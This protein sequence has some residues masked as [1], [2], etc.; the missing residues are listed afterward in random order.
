MIRPVLV[1]AVIVS[2]LAVVNQ[3][4][5]MPELAEEL[6]KP[7]ADDGSIKVKVTSS[8]DANGVLLHG[9][10]GDRD[11]Q[12]VIKFFVT[13]PPEVAGEPFDVEAAQATYVPDD[14]RGTPMRG[15]WLL[16]GVRPLTA[17]L[18][19]DD[20]PVERRV[21]VR[22][23]DDKGFPPAF[24]DIKQLGG[25]TYFLHTALNFNAITRRRFWYEYAATPDLIRGLS[26]SANDSE[27]TDIA[28]FL[29]NRLLR[30]CLALTLLFLTLPQVL[31]GYGRNMFVNLG[32]SLGTAGVFY[33]ANFMSKYLGSHAVISPEMAAWAPLIGFGT[34]AVFRWDA[35]RT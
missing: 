12:T 13:L 7:H 22:L 29:H 34:L 31:G 19:K 16:R 23:D 25:E 18:P 28:V 15:G 24:G 5:I 26:D 33:G 20:T 17:P 27:K 10:A 35:I 8:Y 32:I 30:P 4:F 21:L 14:A 2:G 9:D 3:E 6:M 11:S 1:S